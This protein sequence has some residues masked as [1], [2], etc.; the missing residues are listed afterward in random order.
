[1]N[2]HRG[3]QVQGEKPAA[4]GRGWFSGA[5]KQNAGFV[6]NVSQQEEIITHG[7]RTNVLQIYFFFVE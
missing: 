6:R 7:D 5:P 2:L 3:E 4:V 1:M